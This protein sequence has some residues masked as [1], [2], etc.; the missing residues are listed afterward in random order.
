MLLSLALYI[1]L[2]RR[3][4]GFNTSTDSMISALI[5]VALRTASYTAFVA[6][7]GA[8]ISSI[9]PS[10]NSSV[11]LSV[12][13]DSPPDSLAYR[14]NLT[15]LSAVF[16]LPLPTLYSLSLFTTLSSRETVRTQLSNSGRQPTPHLSTSWITASQD[17]NLVVGI[18]VQFQKHVTVDEE[19]GRR[20]GEGE[21]EEELQ[22]RRSRTLKFEDD[23]RSQR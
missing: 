10:K 12:Y 1:Q 19:N 6:L 9:I 4:H 18:S 7:T 16:F 13:L 14:V 3:K 8:I 20:L 2:S 15:N 22:Q 11:F 17:P 23:V 5:R 21:K